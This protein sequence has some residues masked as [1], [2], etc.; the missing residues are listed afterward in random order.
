VAVLA[1][2]SLLALHRAMRA[3]PAARARRLPKHPSLAPGS[4]GS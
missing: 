4:S 2:L 3:T 1:G